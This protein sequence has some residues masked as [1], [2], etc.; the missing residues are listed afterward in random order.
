MHRSIMCGIAIPGYCVNHVCGH[1]SSPQ[2]CY[3]R[4]M[5]GKEQYPVCVRSAV[6]FNL[7]QLP[8]PRKEPLQLTFNF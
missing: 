7:K 1:W 4:F 5:Q 8:A 2:Y 6:M 3:E